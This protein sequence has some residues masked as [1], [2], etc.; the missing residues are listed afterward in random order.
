MAVYTVHTTYRNI[1]SQTM[2]RV[3]DHQFIADE[4]TIFRGTD[5]GPNPVSRILSIR[6][7]RRLS[8]RQRSLDRSPTKVH[9]QNQEV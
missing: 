4:P 8:G 6:S 3:G 9:R 5:A 7:C 1:G 2:N